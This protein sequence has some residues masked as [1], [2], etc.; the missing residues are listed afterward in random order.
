MDVAPRD[1]DAKNSGKILRPPLFLIEVGGLIAF[2]AAAH[3]AIFWLG[4]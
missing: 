2:G 4:P 3:V 1:S